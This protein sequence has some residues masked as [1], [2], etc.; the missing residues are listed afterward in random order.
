MTTK[1]ITLTELRE[2]TEAKLRFAREDGATLDAAKAYESFLRD[3]ECL[4]LCSA[5]LDQ[6][7]TTEEVAE[8]LRVTAQ[9][10]T[11]YCR[12]GRFQAPPGATF[13]SAYR[14][15]GDSGPWRIPASA[16]VYFIKQQSGPDPVT[17]AERDDF[18]DFEPFLI[19]G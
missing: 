14:T 1:T 2:K 9:T 10:V 4:E 19:A 3:L 11:E 7:Y 6:V 12:T 15:S 16:L 8:R 18:E 13:A 17:G 5:P